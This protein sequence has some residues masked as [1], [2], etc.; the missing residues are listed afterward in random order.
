MADGSSAAPPPPPPHKIQMD[1]DTAAPDADFGILTDTARRKSRSHSLKDCHVQFDSVAIDRSKSDEASITPM[2][3]GDRNVEIQLGFLQ[4]M[5]K[6]DVNFS[7]GG[8][9]QK[10]S[11]SSSSSSCGGS[12]APATARDTGEP[13]IN[14]NARVISIETQSEPVAAVNIKMEVYV[15]TDKVL[16]EKCILLNEED[17]LQNVTLNFHAKVLSK[18]KGTPL[19]KKGIH[20]IEHYE[21]EESEYGS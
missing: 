2:W 17:G 18:D 13:M 11:A 19:L 21:D 14:K 20:C 10:L 5:H 4:F 1:T 3:R 12:S 6:Y 7:L 9:F 15:S 8:P 16:H